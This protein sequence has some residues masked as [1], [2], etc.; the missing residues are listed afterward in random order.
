LILVNADINVVDNN[1]SAALHIAAGKGDI[2]MV[3]ILLRH[4]SINVNAQDKI[5]RTPLYI[6][7][8]KGDDSMVTMLI[9]HGADT[10]VQSQSGKTAMDIANEEENAKLGIVLMLAQTK[11]D[12]LSTILHLAAEDNNI[13]RAMIW[14]H[15]G[16]SI[17]AQ[18]MKGNTPLHVA[19]Y[20]M[21][22]RILDMLLQNGAKVNI[23][24]QDGYTALHVAAYKN[25]IKAAK[26]LLSAGTEVDAQTHEEFTA[27]HCAIIF[28]NV[29]IVKMLLEKDADIHMANKD[30]VNALHYATMHYGNPAV[31]KMLL[32]KGADINMRTVTQWTPLHYAA[33][34]GH[35]DAVNILLKKGADINAKEYKG[36]DAEFF[37]AVNGHGEIVKLLELA[38]EEKVRV[39]NA[40]TSRDLTKDIHDRRTKIYFASSITLKNKEIT[41]LLQRTALD[42]AHENDSHTPV[43]SLRQLCLKRISFFTWQKKSIDHDIGRL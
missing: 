41:Q 17:N 24:N 6:A 23:R 30:G 10:M 12:K 33:Y 7:T 5:G 19:T 16:F 3:K 35:V 36:E 9:E 4:N 43:V 20:Y 42:I 37:A 13:I 31:V 29:E 1:G 2:A 28:N 25:N 32:K 26:K 40:D 39:N 8:E 21:H 34:N 14:I 38:K 15:A 27:L 11:R 18:D 22:D